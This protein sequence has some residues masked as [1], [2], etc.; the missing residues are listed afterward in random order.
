M[1]NILF[2][3]IYSVFCCL[4]LREQG[5]RLGL[6]IDENNPRIFS[7]YRERNFCHLA[8]NFDSYLFTH[9]Q[10]TSCLVKTIFVSWEK[11]CKICYHYSIVCKISQI[12]LLKTISTIKICF[13]WFF[14]HHTQIAKISKYLG[15]GKS[16]PVTALV[17]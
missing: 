9:C 2:C 8:C 1:K 11:S 3:S 10:V 6:R 13:H 17:T 14:E 12:L 16:W 7:S 15:K 5:Q 4:R